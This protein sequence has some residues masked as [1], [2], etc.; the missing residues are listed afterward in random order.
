MPVP[1]DFDMRRPSGAWITEWTL[2]SRERHLA[3]EL[4]AQHHHPRDPEEDDVARRREDVRRV[5]G[6]EGGRVLGPAKGGERPQRRRRTTC[7]ARRGRARPPSHAP[8]SARL[9]DVGLLARGTRPGADGPTR[10]G[11]RCTRGGCSR[12]SRGTRP[13]AGARGGSAGAR[14][15]RVDGGGGE[16]LHVAEPLERD[17]RLDAA[18]ERWEKGTS[19]SR[20]ST[21]ETRPSS[22]SAAT[23]ASRAASTSRPSKPGPAA[24][25]IVPS[26]PI[27]ETSSR[28]WR[29]PISKSC[30]SWPGVILSAP[31]PNSGWT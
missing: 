13:S 5:E 11:A 10:A 7:R 18:P 31:V 30:G 12:A 6:A 8:G 17:E 14:R 3:G 20:G 9:G 24:A 19:W 28:P 1:S 26:S 23:T 21:D 4:D 25:V 15:A 29:R 27:T 16:P 22:R 2:T